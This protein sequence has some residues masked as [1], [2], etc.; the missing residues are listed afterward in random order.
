MDNIV[1][2]CTLC[3]A[4][5]DNIKALQ[6]HINIYLNLKEK[7]IKTKCKYCDKNCKNTVILTEHIKN[8]HNPE[9][10]TNKYL[11]NIC[12]A[13]FTWLPSMERHMRHKHT[14]KCAICLMSF[15]LRGNCKRHT[16]NIHGKEKLLQTFSA[17]K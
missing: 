17:P 5:F 8:F 1:F 14:F 6:N 2:T 11:C 9:T 12:S 10:R 15:S 7:R 3:N 13:P 4:N 16:E